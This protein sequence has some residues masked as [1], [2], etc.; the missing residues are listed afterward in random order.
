MKIQSLAVIFV[1]IIMP[2]SLVLSQYMQSQIKTLNLQTSYDSKLDNATYDAVKTFQLN[3][4]NSGSSDISNSKIRDIEASVNSFFNSV[5]SNL[6]LGESSVET[7]REYVPA[8]VYTL[9]DGFYI[10]SPFT[11]DLNALTTKPVAGSKYNNGD[12][13]YGL[14]PYIYYSREYEIGNTDIVITYSLDNYIS[15]Q[16]YINGE[17]VNRSGYVITPGNVVGN[18][19]NDKNSSGNNLNGT[20]KYRGNNIND[21]R[22]SEKVYYLRESQQGTTSISGSNSGY[23]YI[24]MNGVKY[25]QESKGSYFTV[26]NGN[27]HEVPDENEPEQVVGFGANNNKSAK[28]YY[29]E[30]KEFSEWLISKLGSLQA[31]NGK[32]FEDENRSNYYIFKSNNRTSLEDPNSN[33]NQERLAVIRDSIEDNLSTAIANYNNYTGTT[34]NF[35]MPNLK[36]DEWDKILNHASVISFLQGMP[37]GGKIYNG[38]SIVTNNKNEEV[39]SEDSIYITNGNQYHMVND[40]EISNITNG[41]GIFNVDFERKSLTSD[42]KTNYYLPHNNLGCYNCI[43]NRQAPIDNIYKY[44]E[45]KPDLASIYYTALGRERYGMYRTQNELVY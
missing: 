4:V 8:I 3:T 43:V 23:N 33:F 20:I 44:L 39:V 14:K 40:P 11:N 45:D 6:N 36:E 10:Y 18:Y 21:G 13:I 30:A 22:I 26:L 17:Y 12:S 1:I 5:A 35:Q 19:K 34:T 24:K 27:R 31:S 29:Y 15:V 42:S 32:G 2:I 25:Y 7:I 16:G 28:Q 9:Y 37:I 38:Y 41:Q